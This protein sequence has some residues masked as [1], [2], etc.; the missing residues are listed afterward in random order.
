MYVV[1]PCY[2]DVKK[3]GYKIPLTDNISTNERIIFLVFNKIPEYIFFQQIID[4]S[5]TTIC[6]RSLY[7]FYKLCNTYLYLHKA[8][9][10]YLK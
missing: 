10:P 6:T 1:E 2:L 5:Y 8:Y 9:V 3:D 7:R 4:K